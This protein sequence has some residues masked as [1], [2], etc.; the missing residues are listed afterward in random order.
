MGDA[1]RATRAKGERLLEA[2]IEGLV[3]LVRE[4]RAT[5]LLPRRDQHLAND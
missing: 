2:A 4:L 5:P 3:A 1:T